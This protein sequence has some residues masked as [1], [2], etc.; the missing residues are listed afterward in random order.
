MKKYLFISFLLPM[1]AFGEMQYFPGG[2]TV[3]EIW[4]GASGSISINN[5]AID[6]DNEKLAFVSQIPRTGNIRRAGF[7]TGTITTGGN[8]AARLET[9]STINGNPTGSLYAANCS[10]YTVV[11][12]TQDNVWIN[13]NT[14][15]GTCAVTRGDY[16]AFVLQRETGSTFNGSLTR[17]ADYV[18][19]F[20]YA[21]S[22]VSTSGYVKVANSG[23]FQLEYD[24]GTFA[25]M[26]S[27]IPFS[28][29]N[30]VQLNS[31]SSPRE[32]GLRVYFK[33]R[34]SVTGVQIHIGAPDA[35]AVCNL[36][37]Y[38]FDGA[39]LL[40]SSTIRMALSA[41]T[42]ND[43]NQYLLP[44][45]VI[46]E[47]NQYYRVVVKGVSNYCSIV[48]YTVNSSEI[49]ES[50]PFGSQIHLTSATTVT[51]EAS[52]TNFT[53]RKPVMSLIL[54][55]IDSTSV[56]NKIYQSTINNGVFQ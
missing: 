2:I 53:L 32:Y 20:S 41:G 6:A 22:S 23:P 24:D 12:S 15:D 3:P 38:D 30:I 49:M 43:T 44:E 33:E 48:D 35:T 11:L 9:V 25:F 36:L 26:P 31:T 18:N 8:L 56:K 16:F 47:A 4:K 17:N 50:T 34:V 21:L 14:F 10:T 7:R 29:S 42:A 40:S 54:D 27:V 39:T 1:F 13:G 45:S 19:N 37:V 28:A 5:T 55:G 52:W 51:S 46:F